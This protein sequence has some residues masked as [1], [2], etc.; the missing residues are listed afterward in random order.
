MMVVAWNN[1]SHHESGAGYGVKFDPVDRDRFFKREWGRISVQMDG[2][3]LVDE[4]N[5]DKESFWNDECRELI[6]ADIGR[7]LLQNQ[8]APWKK[9]VP[10][11]LK[12]D[13]I[14]DHLFLLSKLQK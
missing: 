13:V 10:P 7:W 11:K 9:D 2:T 6:S 1:G 4:V 3:D 14:S 12:L 5:I 8:L